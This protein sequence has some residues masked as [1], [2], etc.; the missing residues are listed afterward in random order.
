MAA[1]GPTMKWRAGRRTFACAIATLLATGQ[2]T[3]AWTSDEAP[4]IETSLVLLTRETGS[5]GSGSKGSGSNSI[6]RTSSSRSRGSLVERV[7]ER[8]PEGLVLEYDLAQPKSK[9]RGTD[10]WMFPARVRKAPGQDAVLLNE[11]AVAAR[12]QDW[13]DRHPS[14]RPLCGRY[15]FTWT[16]FRIECDPQAV[17]EAIAPYDLHPGPLSVG[18]PYTEDDALEAR[19]LRSAPGIE[20][21]RGYTV[22]L[23]LD[24]EAL[25]RTDLEVRAAAL[26]VTRD[27]ASALTEEMERLKRSDYSGQ[28]VVTF[29]TDAA[30]RVS[31][32]RRETSIRI[33]KPDGSHETRTITEVVGRKP[34]Q[35]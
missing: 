30:G 6:S 2:P 11:Q 25:R 9:R 31:M 24:P 4:A 14:L 21:G 8:G 28:R 17:L 13:L 5:K 33:E 10:V 1:E 3:P 7:V 19:P 22:T 27:G 35:P 23:S 26:Q 15:V 12:L 18:M 34:D 16:M 29:A 32:R 20:A